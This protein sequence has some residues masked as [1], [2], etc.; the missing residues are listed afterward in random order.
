LLCFLHTLFLI[1]ICFNFQF[2]CKATHEKLVHGGI[3]ADQ[4]WFYIYFIL[5]VDY[6]ISLYLFGN[7]RLDMEKQ[8]SY[9]DLLTLLL[10][11]SLKT[12]TAV[13]PIFSMFTQHKNTKHKQTNT[14]TNTNKNQKYE[15]NTINT[16]K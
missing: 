7:N 9:L 3:L 5:G 2:Q 12:L 1:F 15:R 8:Q 6:F 14:N 16:L 11:W 13:S 10:V 4:V